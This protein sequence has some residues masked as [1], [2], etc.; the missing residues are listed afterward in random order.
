MPSIL[1]GKKNKIYYAELAPYL[2]VFQEGVP[3][4]CYHKLGPKPWGTKL[5]SIY[6]SQTHFRR[7]LEELKAHGFRTVSLDEWSSFG[8]RE[9]KEVVL[10]FDDG[11][12]SVLQYGLEHLTNCQF[13]A[14]NYI[15]AD[16]LGGL[17]AWDM[18]HG[19]VPD[20]LMDETE[21]KEWL[22]AGHSIGSHTCTHPRLSQLTKNRA[23]EEIFS[24]KKKLEDRFGLPITHF[25]Y[26]YGDVK[27]W[28][29]DLVAE[30]GY[31]TAVTLE[32]G[33]NHYQR[34]LHP[35]RLKRLSARAHSINIRNILKR[36][37]GRSLQ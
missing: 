16:H 35:L 31:T 17:N 4:L 29:V 5:R 12:A 24:S 7:Q 36:L 15:V 28:V 14:I 37:T 25:C 23:R 3:I 6:L 21:I 27:P 19:E 13:H 22:A 33:V 30:A 8:T 1:E 2:E 18:V 32:P 11:S 34:G 9:A 10:T 26:P 20:R